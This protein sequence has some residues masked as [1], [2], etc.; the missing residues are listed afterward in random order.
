MRAES[1]AKASGLSIF[2]SK[3][4]IRGKALSS[5]GMLAERAVNALLPQDCL[6]CSAPSG[7]QILCSGCE[8]D[9]PRLATNLCPVCAQPC[10]GGAICGACLHQPPHFDA[11]LASLRYAFPA[12][13][14]IQA[15]KFG[16]RL[17]LAPFL[18]AA[19]LHGPHPVGTLMMPVPLSPRRLRERGFNQALELARPLARALGLPL[20]L[21]SCQRRLDTPPQSLLPWKARRKNIRHAFEC[22]ASLEGA[23]IIVVDDVMTSGATLD[24]FAATLKRHGAARVTNWVAARALKGE[25]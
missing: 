19:M 1:S 5:I 3:F 21:T 7:E 13:K 17:G 20:D 16:H 2:A 18:A 23:S 8:S 25:P 10:P 4:P 15:L 24:E 22:T 6:L 11:T 12:D 9:L 14:L